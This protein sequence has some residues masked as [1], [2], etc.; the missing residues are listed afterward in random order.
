MKSGDL[1]T[2]LGIKDVEENLEVL[3]MTSL[4]IL[5]LPLLWVEYETYEVCR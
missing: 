2:A 4:R 5:S 3:R 1:H